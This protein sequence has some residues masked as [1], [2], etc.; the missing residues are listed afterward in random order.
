MSETVK[1]IDLV[2]ALQ[3]EIITGDEEALQ[4]EIKISD[5]SRPGLELTGYF[6][7]YSY[8]RIQL[9]GSKE[10]TFAQRM[11]P[12][13]RLMVMRRMCAPEIPAFVI[14]RGLEVPKEL[15]QAG[16]EAG[17]PVLRSSV[18]TSRLLGQLS[19][20]LDSKL[21][22]RESVHG[23]LVDVYG[24]GVLIQGSSGIGKSET[25][26]ELIKRGHRLIADD[27]VDVYK[28]DDLTLIGEPPKILEHLI[29][30]R[31]IGIIDVM[32][33]FGASAV[34]GSM[35]V[36][37]AV[38]LEAWEKDKKYDRLGSENATVE[39]GDVA[40]PQIRIPVKTGRNVAIIIEVAAMNFRART[41]GF[42]ATKKFEE[43]LSLLIAENSGK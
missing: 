27:R 4:R 9:F 43:R 11:L 40:I 23:V 41:M 26:L 13:E 8:N 3:L 14:S 6:T 17:I 29:E 16:D 12:E 25:A 18:S 30:I 5:I 37:L 33:L 35:Q 2:N 10:I 7:Y 28:Q 19:S 38:Y 39:I 22:V 1:V 21:A 24:L 32:N 34:R 42:D 31:G 36:Q 20:F 15:I